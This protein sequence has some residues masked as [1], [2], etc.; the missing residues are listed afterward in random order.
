MAFADCYAMATEEYLAMAE[1]NGWVGW[2]MVGREIGYSPF[3]AFP[4]GAPAGQL[5]C[6]WGAGPEVA[7]DN[8]LDLAWA[9]IDE[10]TSER[11]QTKLAADGF[12]RVVAPEGT[13]LAMRSDG[14]GWADAEGFGQAYLFTGDDVRWAQVRDQI[15]FIRQR[16]S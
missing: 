2:D 5:S 6:R 15:R 8:V 12:E 9:P 10:A 14:Q 3:D 11:A 7:T 1:Q 16:S 13:Y 4:E